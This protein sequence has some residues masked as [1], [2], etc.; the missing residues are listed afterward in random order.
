MNRHQDGIS[1][2][3]PGRIFGGTAHKFPVKLVKKISHD[4]LK[5]IQKLC[6]NSQITKETSEKKLQTPKAI[7]E[8]FLMEISGT[9]IKTSVCTS[10]AISKSFQKWMGQSS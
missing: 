8:G 2:G 1:G 5:K 10:D 7:L 3:K 9:P 6:R 4:I